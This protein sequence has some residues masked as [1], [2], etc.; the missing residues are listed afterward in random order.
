[1]KRI[2]IVILIAAGLS[3]SLSVFAYGKGLVKIPSSWKWISDKEVVFSYDGSFADTGAFMVNAANHMVL[4]GVKAPAKFDSPEAFPQGA[5]NPTYSPDSTKLAFTRDNDLYVFD[6]P[7]GKEHRITYDG[8]DNILNGYASWVYY[9]EILGRPSKYRAFWWSPDS[10]KIGFYR[11]DNSMVNVFPIYSP[12]GQDGKLINTRYPKA[13]EKNPSV[14]IGIADVAGSGSGIVW[15]DFDYSVDQYF[16]IPFWGADSR[17]FFISREP[18]LQNT[19]DLYSIDATDGSKKNIYHETYKT[20]LDWIDSMAFGEKGLYMARSFRTGWSQIYFLSYDGSVLDCLTGGRNW[21]VRILRYDKIRDCVYFTA[22]RDSDVRTVLYEVDSK[23]H[24]TALTDTSYSVS[25]VRFSPD[26]KYFAASVSNFTTPSQVWVYETEYANQAWKARR[27]IAASTAFSASSGNH[28]KGRKFGM[29]PAS[30]AFKAADMKTADTDLS[31]YAL[32]SLIYIE[33]DGFRLPAY[34]VYPVNFD[35]SL[36]YPV[37]VDIY[38]GPDIPLVKDRWLNP[39]ADNQWWSEHGIIEV[40]A[41][42]RA[43]GHNGRAGLDM[44]YKHL[45]C[46][47][48]DDFIAWARYLQSLPYVI[49]DKIGVEGFSFGGTMT[50]MLLFTASKYYHYGIAGGGVYDWSLYDT[51]YTERYMDTPGANPEGY[52][53]SRV[54]DYVGEYPVAYASDASSARAVEPVMLK[55]T[56]GTGDDNVHFQQTEQLID[57][58]QKQGKKFEFMIYPDGKHGYHGYQKVHFIEA[59]HE[60]WLKYL[61]Q[62]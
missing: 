16:G 2:L 52:A 20:W 9:E 22:D 42:C 24:I 14:R 4:K 57:E 38:G 59:N 48:I 30:Y 27:L 44:I 62:P 50:A 11:F 37:H 33:N 58:M 56:H 47:E 41:D 19:L 34:I 6:I 45:N 25:N 5:V 7:E 60:F 17:E 43:S 12:F 3:A 23:K 61:L 13:G 40:T 10:K 46:C 1:M 26:C 51:H 53:K 21:N 35:P 15:A 28:G 8:S 32:P 54:M 39:S 55:L 36:K 49:P 31:G 29:R 18:R